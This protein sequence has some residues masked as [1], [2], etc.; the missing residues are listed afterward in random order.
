MKEE[1]H[2]VNG[3]RFAGLNIRGFSLMK[4]F[5]GIFHGALVSSVYYLTITKYSQEN[6]HGTLKNHENHESLAQQ[7]FFRLR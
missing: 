2:T 6:F 4:F 1:D 7:I 5:T 3:E